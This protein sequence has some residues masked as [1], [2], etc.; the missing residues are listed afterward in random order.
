TLPLAASEAFESISETSALD[1]REPENESENDIYDAWNFLAPWEDVPFLPR[2]GMPV[3]AGHCWK[4]DIGFL[5]PTVA[6]QKGVTKAECARF[7]V[8][9]ELCHFVSYSDSTCEMKTH[10]S[11]PVLSRGSQ[12]TTVSCVMGGAGVPIFS[13]EA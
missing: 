6:V 13:V 9:F 11:E 1:T 8:A 3:A 4:K 12:G 10:D 5:G 7:C 2:L